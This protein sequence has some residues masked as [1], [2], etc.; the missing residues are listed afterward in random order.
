MTTST[1]RS[2][3]LNV[4]RQID[5]DIFTVPASSTL[6]PGSELPVAGCERAFVHLTVAT[7]AL[8]G[9]VIQ[10]RVTNS[11]AWFDIISAGANFTTPKAPLIGAS[12]DITALGVGSG[13]FVIGT[14]GLESIR[15]KATSGGTAT[16]VTAM[17][18][19]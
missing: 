5:V 10:G 11:D 4:V 13:W 12:G 15:L 6:I 19:N 18:A 16:V 7:A 1:S 2:M 3:Q 9:F 14:R 8:T 17:C